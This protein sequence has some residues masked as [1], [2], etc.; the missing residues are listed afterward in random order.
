MDELFD[1]LGDENPYKNNKPGQLN[2]R[3]QLTRAQSVPGNLSATTRL[4][5]TPKI[6]GGAGPWL[7]TSSVASAASVPTGGFRFGKRRPSSSL[8]IPKI[9]RPNTSSVLHL[10][11]P[12]HTRTQSAPMDIPPAPIDIPMDAP[13]PPTNYLTPNPASPVVSQPL[14]YGWEYG[15]LWD[16]KPYFINHLNQTTSWTDPRT[17]DQ[18]VAEPIGDLAEATARL[19]LVESEI[20][21]LQ[22]AKDEIL[23]QIQT[24]SQKLQSGKYEI[25]SP[26]P[27]ITINPASYYQNTAFNSQASMDSVRSS[28]DSYG[29]QNFTFSGQNQPSAPA[30]IPVMPSVVQTSNDE[31]L[32]DLD[33]ISGLLDM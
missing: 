28:A 6:P 17:Q 10:P 18:Q 31:V 25:N 20:R 12:S 21:K 11:E 9:I 13:P 27:Q 1:V 26:I 5:L 4:P 19:Q 8:G 24:G 32:D 3:S 2:S 7:M 15:G 16:G 22:Q 23:R 29:S 33:D 14:P 30:S